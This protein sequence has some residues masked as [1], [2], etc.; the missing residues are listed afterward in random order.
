MEKI[1]LVDMDDVI[2]VDG[3]LNM[4]NEYMGT[5]YTYDD[6]PT[7]YMQDI[8]PDKDKFFTWFKEKNMYD[9]CRLNDDCYEVLEKLNKHY[10]LFI[11]TS[12]IFREI[13]RDS[14]H[15]LYQKFEYLKDKLPFINPEQYIFISDKSVLKAYARIDDRTIN[16]IDGEKKVLF[17]AYHNGDISDEELRKK[18]IKRARNWK[19]VE[20]ILLEEI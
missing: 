9:Y 2:T 19:D 3:F 12:Y 1:L 4:L 7:F 14:G 17:S 6:F 5:D 20:K 13:P 15:I 8:L 11:A 18:G 16:L 10:K